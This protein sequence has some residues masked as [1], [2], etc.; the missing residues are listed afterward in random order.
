MREDLWGFVDGSEAAPADTDEARAKY[1]SRQRKTL[2]TISL[3]IEENLLYLLGTPEDPRALWEKLATL[4][5]KKTWSNRMG[6]KRKLS[7]LRLTS[8][9]DLENHLKQMTDVMDELIAVDSY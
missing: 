7:A 6:L 2:G 1:V 9:G 4:F 3:T 5:Q 8:G